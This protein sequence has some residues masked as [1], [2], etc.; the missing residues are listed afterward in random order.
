MKRSF[1]SVIDKVL[2]IIFS[3][4]QVLTLRYVIFTIQRIA[5]TQACCSRS[6]AKGRVTNRF[7]P[8]KRPPPP[9]PPSTEKRQ[10]LQSLKIDF[11]SN[12]VGRIGL[13]RDMVSILRDP[14]RATRDPVL[15]DRP[16]LDSIT[17][18]SSQEQIINCE[19]WIFLGVRETSQDSP[20]P[21]PPKR[22]F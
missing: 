5:N 17:S 9:P 1:K 2:R 12:W 19:K 13:S 7:F 10:Y 16:A 15:W 8:E 22:R 4:L 14:R 18:S 6:Y 11:F 21:P 20:L 3:N